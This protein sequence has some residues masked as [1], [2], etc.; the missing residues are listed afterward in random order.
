MEKCMFSKILNSE[1]GSVFV[2]VA[3]AAFMLITATGA[4]VD[5]AR[6]QILQ[7]KISTAL[8]AAGL[9]AGATANTVNVQT[10]ATKYFNAN[11]P[12]GYL[13]SAA[14]TV[15]AT[16]STDKS[17]INLSAN[18]TQATTFMKA[19]GVNS[20]AV[21]ATSQITRANQGM[22]LILVLDNTGSMASAVN[23]SNSSVTKIQALK[24]SITSSGGLLDIIYGTNST[25]SNFWIGV[26]PFTDMVNIG[27]SHS[28]WLDTTYNSALDFG[29][30]IT[31]SSCPTYAGVTPNVAGTYS[32]SPARCAYTITGS[33]STTTN[34]HL[35]NWG[36]CVL[37]RSETTPSAFP[38]DESDVAPTSGNAATL[39]QAFYYPTSSTS[40]SSSNTCNGGGANSWTC[41]KTSG[42]GSS[43]STTTVYDSTS[44]STTLGPNVG[45]VP[46]PVLAMTASK[47]N[48]VTTIN[49][50]VANGSTMINLGL[51]WGWRML[52]PNWTGLWGGEM[53]AN[54][55]QLPLPYHTALMNKVVVLMTD[56]MNSGSSPSAY[57]NQT[58]PS[59]AQLDTRTSAIC[60]A[61]KNAGIII[62]TIGFGQNGNNNASDP[63][64]VNGP[65][66]QGC[67]SKPSYYFL[68]PTNAQLQTAFQQIGDSLANLRVSQ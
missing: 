4:A 57:Q 5:M 22:E 67:A 59:N 45:C 12:S 43:K 23:S 7:N 33:S 21:G 18:T 25:L 51:A 16:L 38:Y 19:V 58:A 37:S 68:A 55:P 48:V 36:G 60:T 17:T 24:D 40:T 1:Q 41:N 29:P 6:A 26:V 8:D 20:V 30:V 50:M 61:M 32:T 62:Y 13:S 56:G 11:F 65:L 53:N 39:F 49:S 34:F 52:S 54:S 14:V 42:S 35:A 9:A 28:T 44:G 2:M 15:V 10:Q 64:S 63:Y 47:N 66:L 31:S 3:A 27:T 46:T